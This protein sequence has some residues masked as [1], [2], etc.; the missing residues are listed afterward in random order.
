MMLRITTKLTDHDIEALAT[1]LSREPVP[2]SVPETVSAAP[3]PVVAP[4]SVAAVPVASAAVS[5]ILQTLL[6]AKPLHIQD[7]NFEIGSAKLK[8]KVFKI[9]DEVVKFAGQKPEAKL[10]LTGYTDT[11]G[12]ART[13]Q[14]LSVARAESVKKYL[15][16]NGVSADRITTKGEGPA[17]PVA[18]NNT[19]EGRAKNRRV[20]IQSVISEEKKT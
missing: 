16:K 5:E 2:P 8:P 20:D 4:E 7:T 19:K 15:V 9:L 13:N 12:S 1:Y 3:Q 17:N 6:D 18:D 14:K 10:A 11:T